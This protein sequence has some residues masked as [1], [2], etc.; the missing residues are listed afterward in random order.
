MYKKK[1][2]EEYRACV[3]CGVSHIIEN[4]MKW[5]CK[6]CNS[7]ATRERR[8]DLIQL[9]E[10]IWNERKHICMK[11]GVSLGDDPKPI[12]FS[13]ILSR[14]AHSELKMDKNNIELL[15]M[16]CHQKHEFGDRNK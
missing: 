7:E 16:E 3:K 15:C 1:S 13:H 10:E 14:G 5:L 12:Y 6:D 11:C 9:F 4:R 8:G 2:K